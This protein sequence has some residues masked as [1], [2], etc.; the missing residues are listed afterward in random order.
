MLWMS[1]ETRRFSMRSRMD[2]LTL[3]NFSSK[4]RP[5]F[6]CNNKGI[7]ALHLACHVGSSPLISLVL[8]QP[9]VKV[10]AVDGTRKSSLH[11]AAHRCTPETLQLLLSKGAD[12]E[13]KDLHGNTP[14]D[15]AQKLGKDSNTE[16]LRSARGTPAAAAAALPAGK[17]AKDG[18]GE[19]SAVKTTAE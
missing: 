14:L 16:L 9:G 11:V 19:Q 6:R 10:N 2:G 3:R 4:P 1:T 5:M 18:S 8:E 15:L 12:S 13:V 7:S 17:T